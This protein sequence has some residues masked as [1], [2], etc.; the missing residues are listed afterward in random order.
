MDANKLLQKIGSDDAT[1]P[2]IRELLSHIHS[3]LGGTEAYAD[4]IAEDVKAAPTGSNQRMTFHNNYLGAVAK[5]GGNDDLETMAPEALQ[6]E[7]A[8]LAEQLGA[9]DASPSD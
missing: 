2:D 7:A 3:F 5:F 9:D 4:M 6:A 1:V 8:R